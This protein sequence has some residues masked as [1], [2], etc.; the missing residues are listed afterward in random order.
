LSEAGLL[1]LH[2]WYDGKTDAAGKF[3]RAFT[4]F[5]DLYATYGNGRP[6]LGFHEGVAAAWEDYKRR[7]RTRA[8]DILGAEGWIEADIRTGRILNRTIDSIEIHDAKS[9][10]NN[11]LV[12]WQNRFGHANRDHHA[13]LDARN[14][15]FRRREFESLLFDLYRGGGDEGTVFERLSELSGGK[16]RLIA[17]LFFV[18]V[19]F[20]PIQNRFD[21][22]FK[23]MGIPF[24]TLRQCNWTN[25]ST[26]VAL[27]AG[28]RDRIAAE[29]KL[30]DVR[31]I[32]AQSFC[33]IYLHY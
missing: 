9:N 15:G 17:Y 19:R 20:A 25:Y 16:Y 26:F 10:L 28:F 24:T 30:T 7:L 8:Q 32:N 1:E 18:K 12:F 4:G 33:W 14:N 22:A 29:T 6:F 23:T 13:L 11:N 27:L 5:R 31:L 3:H 21:R 2:S